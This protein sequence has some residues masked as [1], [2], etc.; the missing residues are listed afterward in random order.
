MRYWFGIFGKKSEY[1]SKLLNQSD[2]LDQNNHKVHV[3]NKWAVFVNETTRAHVS[4]DPLY[5][6]EGN[7]IIS[8]HGLPFPKDIN[9]DVFL[10]DYKNSL[11]QI[12]RRNRNELTKLPLEFDNGKFVGCV[13]MPTQNRLLLF[14][15]FLNH[16]PLYYF[17][18][19]DHLFFST[20]LTLLIGFKKHFGIKKNPAGLAEYL[21]YGTN[22]TDQTIVEDVYC[23]PK[24]S[25]LE[26]NG[27]EL[28]HENY[29]T[30]PQTD[31]S[32][33]LDD[34][35]NEAKNQWDA[36]L[37][38]M[39]SKRFNYGL[40]ITGGVDSRFI[41]A[42][43]PDKSNLKIFTGTHPGHIDYQNA[44]LLC[45]RIGLNDCHILE[46]YS[47]FSK[48]EIFN[49]FLDYLN[50]F[51]NPLNLNC[52]V[53]DLQQNWRIKNGIDIQLN[54]YGGETLGGEHYYTT[55][56][57]FSGIIKQIL[58]FRFI[59]LNT[60]LT[61]YTNYISLGLRND[62]FE[63]LGKHLNGSFDKIEL[64]RNIVYDYVVKAINEDQYAENFLER[65]RAIYKYSNL[66][67]Y[68]FLG[69]YN[70]F[71][72]LAPYFSLSFLDYI[73][74]IPLTMRH[75]RKLTFLIYKKFFPEYASVVLSGTTLKPNTPFSI[76]KLLKPIY[77]GL[78]HYNLRI[79][80][81]KFKP[82]D[83]NEDPFNILS[84]KEINDKIKQFILN[85][86]I[87]NIEL[88]DLDAMH[89]PKKLWR[90]FMVAVAEKR[91]FNQQRNFKNLLGI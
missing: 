70:F 38:R 27:H 6:D 40:G 59:N 22:I 62:I 16:L 23:L 11:Y 68:D 80:F 76:Y 56:D 5:F 64:I 85:S 1:F 84:G 67:E 19:E 63:D 79:P 48:D 78:N 61:A 35:I 24:F 4:S 46:D 53:T 50:Y 28:K 14:N 41:L 52:V 17:H 7:V 9:L 45:K 65:F 49:S 54:G 86:E 74:K 20:S 36:A 21:I 75:D 10:S 25:I 55:R 83:K 15:S 31:F 39:I 82:V 87:L 88:S 26:F 3:D 81:S 47:T 90:L 43:W 44:K 73:S 58:P 13:L 51:D 71:N 29:Y 18:N 33:Q 32:M 91:F 77:K 37:D 8:L 2:L 69:A 57:T 30:F 72:N 66:L 60:D 34:C 89:S 12:F 42:N